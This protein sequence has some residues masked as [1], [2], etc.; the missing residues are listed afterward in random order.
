M[1]DHRR[2][3]RGGGETVRVENADRWFQEQRSMQQSRRIPMMVRNSTKTLAALVAAMLVAS[4]AGTAHAACG[5]LNANSSIDP[6]DAVVL[7]QELGG[8][9]TVCDSAP[10]DCDLDGNGSTGVGDIVFMLN[11]LAGVETLTAPCAGLGPVL[12]CGSSLSGNVTSNRQLPAGCDT[13][14]DGTV[15]VQPNVT[16]TVRAGA[17]VKG[18]RTSTNGSPSVLLVLQDAKLNAPGTAANPVVFTSDAPSGT[19]APGDWGGVVLNGRAPVNVPG[20]VGSTEGLPPG[21]GLFGG[22]EPNDSSGLVRFARL[23]FSGIEF[24]T[25]N[26]L[27]VFTQNGVGRGSVIDHVHANAGFD[28]CIEW[29]GGTVQEKFLVA[30]GCRDDL[31][32]WQ[33]GYTGAL[34]FGLAIQNAAISTGSGRNGIEADNNENG[35]DFAPRSNPDMCNLTVVGS[36]GQGDTTGGRA[37]ALLRRGTAGVI[38]NSIFM[39]WSQACL[40]LDGNSTAAVACD[41]GPAL[42]P[43]PTNLTVFDSVC[44]NNGDPA[45]APTALSP[46]HATGSAASPCTPSQWYSLLAATNGLL[47]ASETALGPNPGITTASYPAVVDNRWF[48]TNAAP[49]SGAPDCEDVNPDYFDPAPYIGAFDPTNNPGGNWLSTPWINFAVN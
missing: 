18:K 3:D 15:K 29:F 31:F 28:D 4:G 42:D 19:R 27:N 49:F 48:P 47:P 41:A 9:T 1:I 25:D 32:D 45:N 8:G 20:G 6:G 34:Q 14:V 36:K 23:E 39:D 21:E 35:N 38:A 22:N 26:E 43:G 13:F 46:D 37:G 16:L 30:S 7:S 40:Q 33:L 11:L 10:A 44:F 2:I 24:S 17:T 5:D 12:G